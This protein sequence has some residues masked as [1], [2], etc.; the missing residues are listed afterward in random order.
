MEITRQNENKHFSC[1][2]IRKDL[3]KAVIKNALE[4][5]IILD[6]KGNILDVNEAFSRMHGYSREEL[7]SMKVYDLSPVTITPEDYAEFTKGHIEM[8][9][10]NFETRHR[11][12]D[13]RVI[14]VLVSSKYLDVGGIFFSFHR[15]ITEQKREQRKERKLLKQTEGNP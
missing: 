2:D 5:F 7:L 1:L 14:D 15:D 4:G 3:Y 8:G 10:A 6:L 11:R 9:G 12:K 13:G